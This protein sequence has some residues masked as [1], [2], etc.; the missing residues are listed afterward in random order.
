MHPYHHEVLGDQ[1]DIESITRNELFNHYRT[2][3]N[4]SNAIVV[5]VGDFKTSQIL[6]TIRTHFGKI[7]KGIMPNSFTR[8]EPTQKGERKVY[9]NGEGNTAYLPVSYTH[10]TL[11][12]I[13]SV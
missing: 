4:P 1:V 10:L 12:T 2:F 6:K 11:P 8:N 3:Y 13:Y 5:A 7:P 9:L